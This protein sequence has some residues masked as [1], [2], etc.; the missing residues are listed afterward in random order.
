MDMLL[1][2]ILHLTHQKLSTASGAGSCRA[3][4]V[5]LHDFLRRGH[6]AFAD[7]ACLLWYRWRVVHLCCIPADSA[8]TLGLPRLFLASRI[9]PQRLSQ[10]DTEA[11][12]STT[13]AAPSLPEEVEGEDALVSLEVS[14]NKDQGKRLLENTDRYWE[15][16]GPSGTHWIEVCRLCC[17]VETTC[18]RLFASFLCDRSSVLFVHLVFPLGP[19]C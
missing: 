2:V 12:A 10:R 18:P 13:V 7:L 6:R 15:S 8:C 4:V 19:M 17:S 9:S 5:P 1:F 3:A 16:S 14:T 11:A